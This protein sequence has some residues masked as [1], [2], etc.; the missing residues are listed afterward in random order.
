MRKIILLLLMAGVLL[1]PMIGKSNE[2]VSNRLPRYGQL[3]LELQE[4]ILIS[5]SEGDPYS[6]GRFIGDLAVDKD[7]ALFVLDSD[8]VLKYDS[9]GK[10]IQMIGSKGEGPGEFQRPNRIF[11]HERGDLYISEKLRILHVFKNDGKFVK[12][13][14]LSF[15]ISFETNNLFIDRDDNIYAAAMDIS[16][17]GPKSIL[18]KAD[19]N[20]K[21]LKKMETIIDY[22]TKFTSSSGGGGVMGGV[23]HAYSERLIFHPVKEALL[24][25][26]TNTKYEI[27]LLDLNGNL[28]T[29]V[30]KEEDARLISA[31]EKK[32][33]GPEAV[34]PS[35]RPFFENILSDEDGRIYILKTKSILDKSPDTE[36]DIF[37][38]NGH[39]LYRTEVPFTP[40]LIVNGSFYSIE[41]DE[42]QLRKIKKWVIQ[43]YRELKNN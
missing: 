27:F 36:I 14:N 13:I 34:F 39:Y 28:K 25:Y 43:N 40:R 26:G 3:K 35:H 17:S 42:N 24:C 33:L 29:E 21:I 12:K 23:S 41:Q 8:R 15:I 6:F 31:G 2:I 32:K 22:D 18:V 5:E 9:Q 38:A 1:L 20:G 19:P 37:G 7:G 10:F 11:I 30:S 4:N 16:D